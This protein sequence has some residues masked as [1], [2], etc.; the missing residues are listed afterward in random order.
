MKQFKNFLNE[1]YLIEAISSSDFP[2]AQGLIKKYLSKYLG[3]NSVYFYP[4]PEI[5]TSRGA[6]A[7]GIRIYLKTGRAQAF[8]LNWSLNGGST[9]IVSADYWDGSKMP[10]PNPSH[11]IKFEHD[12]SLATVLP[13]VR[14]FILGKV[15]IQH[16]VYM[17]EQTESKNTVLNEITFTSSR[18]FT[19]AD[20]TKT[21]S[22]TVHALKM[23]MQFRQQQT[24]GGKKRFGPKWDE[25]K[26]AIK[27]LYPE[28][29]ERAGM[30]GAYIISKD[31]AEKINIQ[32]VVAEILGEKGV[33]G[34]SVSTGSP[35]KIEVPGA[36]QEDIERMSYEEQLDSL[37]TGMRL[38]MANA[39]NALFIGG[40]G[41]TGKTQNVE[42]MLHGA[43]K[44]DGEGY[45]KITG[46][47][48]P[49]GIY[50]ILYNHRKDIVLFDDSDSALADQEGRNLFKAASDTKKI[51]KISWMKGGK[52]FV[53]PADYDE[54]DEDSDTLPRYFEF[55]GKIIFISN[56]ALNKLDPDG[57]LRTRGY[58]INVDPTNEEIY[59]FMI[60]IA[61]K[62]PLDVNHPLSSKDRAEVVDVLRSR[63]IAE[64]S[65][66]LRTL[67]RALNTR[68]GVEQQGGTKEEWI[69][70]VKMFA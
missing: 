9:S 39:T 64:K 55:T 1:E 50:R 16:D 7:V 57:A 68:A 19:T 3:A 31:N 14:D 5:F 66:N 34:Y 49:V 54:D 37:R 51:R 29:F 41:G 36:S 59:D 67:V 44:S 63:K 4:H 62:I 45:F 13:F 26:D 21:V 24:E 48:T 22:N 60:K 23:G 40:R 20:I 47:A 6:R 35:E 42:D 8:R 53:D 25:V 17:Q 15:D 43:G 33:I 69:K 32:R 28:L 12:Q 56:L 2:K 61:D 70:F 27:K 52:N 38:L 58:V 11:H 30:G 46:S 18:T 65:A 10:Q